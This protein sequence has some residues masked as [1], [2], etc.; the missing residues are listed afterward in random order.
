MEDA[1]I[2]KPELTDKKH[3]LFG[4]FDGHGG[5]IILTQ[6]LKFHASQRDIS[7]FN[8]KQTPTIKMEIINK[9]LEKLS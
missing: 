6:A 1:H 3:A 9:P 2:S 8:W 5:T 4:V 7:S